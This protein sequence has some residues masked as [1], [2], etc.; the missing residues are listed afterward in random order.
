MDRM[1]EMSRWGYRYVDRDEVDS[2]APISLEAMK[3]P[4][5]RRS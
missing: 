2:A 4:A 5:Y 1:I 3:P